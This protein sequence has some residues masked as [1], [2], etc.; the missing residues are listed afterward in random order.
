[1]GNLDG[2]IGGIATVSYLLSFAALDR[3]I[4]IEHLEY[5]VA[6]E[7][8]GQPRGFFDFTLP[9]DGTEHIVDSVFAGWRV[10]FSWLFR[11]PL[12]LAE[13]A[14]GQ[15]LLT[16]YRAGILAANALLIGAAV[17]SAT[18]ASR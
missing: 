13:S 1:V 7:G 17:Y 12:W 8:D 11:T 9:I 16:L 3:L 5:P 14:S 2:W 18:F 6:W 15:R 10:A 4:S